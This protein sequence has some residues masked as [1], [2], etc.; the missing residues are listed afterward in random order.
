MGF[1]VLENKYVR[2]EMSL[3]YN[4]QYYF[5]A[6]DK[7]HNHIGECDLYLTEDKDVYY[8]GNIGYEIFPQY[9]GHHYSE[10]CS[11]LLID[12]AS[13]I[14]V[15]Q[16]TLTANPENLPSIKIINN[17]GAK[18]IEVVKVPK[19]SRLYKNGDRYLE[20]YMIN[21]EGDKTL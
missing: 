17:L 3:H 19:K 11:K 21:M 8:L 12:L 9:R 2:L 7:E 6:Y 5:N 10:E 15:K 14:G 16:V 18:F 1:E 4:D 20:R 13:K